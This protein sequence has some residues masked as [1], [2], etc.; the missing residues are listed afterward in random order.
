M[1]HLSK[2]VLDLDVPFSHLRHLPE[3]ERKAIITDVL[4][5]PVPA[6]AGVSS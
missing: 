1:T 3:A 5:R 4:A 2:I 6:D